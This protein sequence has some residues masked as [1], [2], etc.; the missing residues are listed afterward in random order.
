MNCLK[1][2][3]VD[4]IRMWVGHDSLTFSTCCNQGRIL[5]SSKRAHS[6]WSSNTTDWACIDRPNCPILHNTTGIKSKWS[7]PIKSQ[8]RAITGKQAALEFAKRETRPALPL[9]VVT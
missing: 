3:L 2:L 7:W 5:G 9:V 6:I 4:C 8:G 1:V